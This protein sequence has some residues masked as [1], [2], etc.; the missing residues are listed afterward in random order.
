[1]SRTEVPRVRDEERRLRMEQARR[2]PSFIQ[3]AIADSHCAAG[4]VLGD[5]IAEYG[6]FAL[7]WILFG[8]TLYAEYAGDLLLAWLFGIAFQYFTIKPMRDLSAVAAFRPSLRS[9]TLAIITFEIGLF[10]WMGGFLCRGYCCRGDRAFPGSWDKN[11]NR[12]DS[13]RESA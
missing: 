4:F 1:M 7:A 13:A 6:L 9:D 8:R 3:T 11:A 2:D 12:R 10:A 5:L